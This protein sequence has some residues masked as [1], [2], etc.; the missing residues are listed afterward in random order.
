MIIKL[1]EQQYKWLSEAK[2]IIKRNK[3][4][5]IK[6][7]ANKS[8][9]TV[10]SLND[11]KSIVSNLGI[12][13]SNVEEYVGKYCF[14]EVGSSYS[15][16]KAEFP[17]T[18]LKGDSDTFYNTEQWYFKNEHQNVLKMEFDDNQKFNNKFPNKDGFDGKTPT[19]AVKL[20]S[21]ENKYGKNGLPSIMR[22][23]VILQMKWHKD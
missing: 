22:M 21:A 14:I 16:I 19:T 3:I 23:E 11:F 7:I 12:N 5:E 10:T 8:N 1:T 4:N 2:D 15:R 17:H 9:I 20:S 18:N 6:H 13:D